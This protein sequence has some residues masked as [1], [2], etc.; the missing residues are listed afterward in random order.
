MAIVTQQRRSPI[1]LLLLPTLLLVLAR[2]RALAGALAHSWPL[3]WLCFAF[4]SD[5]R[6]L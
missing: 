1:V 4:Y 2:A 3:V 5:E 6:Q